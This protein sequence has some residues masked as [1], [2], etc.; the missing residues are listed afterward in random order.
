M[1]L[2]RQSSWH[3]NVPAN[4]GKERTAYNRSTASID[5]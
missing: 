2:T 3:N 4:S 1:L 5:M